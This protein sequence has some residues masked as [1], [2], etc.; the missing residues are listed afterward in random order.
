MCIKYKTKTIIQLFI[1]V[2]ICLPMILAGPIT[3]Y[4]LCT[5]CCGVVHSP[6]WGCFG[7][8]AMTTGLCILEACFNPMPGIVPDPRDIPC[9]LI[10]AS[11]FLLP[12]P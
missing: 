8:G 4:S 7:L 10:Y 12:T 2:A 5:G 1:I 11:S 9:Q 6:D 3:A